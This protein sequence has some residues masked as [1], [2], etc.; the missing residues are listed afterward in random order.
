[1]CLEI[2]MLGPR[3]RY[4]YLRGSIFRSTF[5]CPYIYNVDTEKDMCVLEKFQ[6]CRVFIY[7]IDNEGLTAFTLLCSFVPV[8][9]V[10]PASLLKGK[11]YM[12]LPLFLDFSQTRQIL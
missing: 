6:Q 9:F 5:V 4:L 10:S 8:V 2:C 11:K 3:L 1:M 7:V 12:P